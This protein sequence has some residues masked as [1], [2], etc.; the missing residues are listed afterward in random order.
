MA[1]NDHQYRTPTVGTRWTPEQLRSRLAEI[2]CPAG[3]LVAIPVSPMD[4]DPDRTR[5]RARHARRNWLLVWAVM[6]AAVAAVV[7]LPSVRRSALAGMGGAAVGLVI[8]V[9]V[10]WQ[11]RSRV[12]PA[13]P[14]EQQ[15]DEFVRR[16]LNATQVVRGVVGRWLAFDELDQAVLVTQ[17]ERWTTGGPESVLQLRWGPEDGSIASVDLIRTLLSRRVRLTFQDGSHVSLSLAGP[18]R[19]V[20]ISADADS[21]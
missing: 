20:L 13:F 16:L 6:V 11:E 7:L 4:L 1:T 8:Q 21:V 14:P 9:A 5:T 17:E 18:D 10:A 2:A 15:A 3:C 19:D 12:G